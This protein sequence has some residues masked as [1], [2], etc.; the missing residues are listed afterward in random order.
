MFSFAC[1]A[2]ARTGRTVCVTVAAAAPE[3]VVGRRSPSSPTTATRTERQQMP[4]GVSLHQMLYSACCMHAN[5][6]SKHISQSRCTLIIT[7]LIHIAYL[8]FYISACT[9]T[10]ALATTSTMVSLYRNHQSCFN[11]CTNLYTPYLYCYYFMFSHY[12]CYLVGNCIS[13]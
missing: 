13:H 8:L 10:P 3:R 9:L 1:L 7:R 5:R 11:T 2:L 4:C 6:V 12:L